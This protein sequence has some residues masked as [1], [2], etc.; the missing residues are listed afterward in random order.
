M[1]ASSIIEVKMFCNSPLNVIISLRTNPCL[2][3]L[4]EYY[5]YEKELFQKLQ[6]LT[7]VDQEMVAIN[8]QKIPNYMHFYELSQI[9]YY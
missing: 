5:T 1:L 8:D 2:K 3:F 9:T 6:F 7:L 4:Q